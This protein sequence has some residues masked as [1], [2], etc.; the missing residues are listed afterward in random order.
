MKNITLFILLLFLITALIDAQDEIPFKHYKISFDNYIEL[1]KDQ[2]F[3]YAAEKLNITISEAAI[4]AAKVFSDP[5]ISVDYNRDSE[6]GVNSGFGLSSEI[7]KS[8]DLGG[9]RKA[10]I[11]LSQSEKELTVSL[12]T[13]YYRRLQAEATLLYLEAMKQRQLYLVKYDS[14]QTM[15]KLAESDSIR[16]TLGSIMEIDA[17]QSKLEAGILLNELTHAISEWKNS[18]WDISVMTGNSN[19]DTLLLPSNHLHDVSRDFV[20]EDL[21]TE[22]LNNRA[23]LQAA[24]LDKDVS[25]KALILTKKERNTDIDLR[26]GISNSYLIGAGAPV[27]SS[28]SA[29]IAIPLKFSNLNSG[30]LR[31]AEARID[32]ANTRYAYAEVKIVS[33]I[34]QAWEYY[35]DYC[36]QVENFNNGLLENAENVRKGKI[37]S[38]QRGETSLL[39]VLNAQRTYNEIQTTFFETLFNQAAAL[40]NLE[41]AAGIWDIEF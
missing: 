16:Y 11:N 17:I 4:E 15:N 25:Q 5:Y 14:Y 24:L 21:I 13:D 2:N 32:L 18:L 37:Y 31:M 27:N 30:E 39:E 38:Y 34:T 20:L 6:S 8:I 3:E 1:V 36:L 41:M 28:L 23:D 29:G 12:V 19:I 26:A 10:R 7:G 35:M 22:A 9:E 40:V 33:E